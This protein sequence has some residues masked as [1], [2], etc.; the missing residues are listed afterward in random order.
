VLFHQ[1]QV[2]GSLDAE[3]LLEVLSQI[4]VGSPSKV[5][6]QRDVTDLLPRVRSTKP[7]RK[8]RQLALVKDQHDFPING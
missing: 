3:S 7:F 1:P 6:L 8:A 5:P 2:L 4:F